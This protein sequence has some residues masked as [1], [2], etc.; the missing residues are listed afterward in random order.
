MGRS[1]KQLCFKSDKLNYFI[2]LLTLSLTDSV[3]GYGSL[4][5]TAIPVKMLRNT[6]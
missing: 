2:I 6:E 5:K 3:S 4:N 1:V